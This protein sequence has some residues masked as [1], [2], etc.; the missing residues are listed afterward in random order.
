MWHLLIVVLKITVPTDMTIEVWGR[1]RRLLESIGMSVGSMVG[2]VWH[3]MRLHHIGVRS[4][5]MV[6]HRP[7]CTLGVGN[8]LHPSSIDAQLFNPLPSVLR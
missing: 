1:R 7:I 2:I 6:V 4:R 5:G 3:H 8:L